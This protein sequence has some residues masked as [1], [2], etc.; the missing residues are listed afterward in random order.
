VK[1][2]CPG[3]HYRGKR[4]V[5]F[6]PVN[7]GQR[8]ARTGKGFARG[9]DHAGKLIDRVIADCHARSKAGAW[10][11]AVG[12]S[13]LAVATPSAFSENSEKFTPEPSQVAPSG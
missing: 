4:F 5:Y 1:L 9:R 7:V 10:T 6:N 3:Q 12:T 2:A 11:E 8:Q 13:S